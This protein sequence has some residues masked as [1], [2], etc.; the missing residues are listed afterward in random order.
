M[1][2]FHLA[3]NQ[4]LDSWEMKIHTEYWVNYDGDSSITTK[5]TRQCLF[6]SHMM[7][8]ILKHKKGG[9]KTCC[10]AVRRCP[11]SPSTASPCLQSV[12]ISDSMNQPDVGRGRL[13]KLHVLW[14]FI[15]NNNK[16]QPALTAATAHCKPWWKLSVICVSVTAGQGHYVTPV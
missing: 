1:S 12:L 8:C 3:I 10:W 7:H 6:D 9:I 14:S 16:D 13:R 5:I 15:L 4:S 2:H 11:P